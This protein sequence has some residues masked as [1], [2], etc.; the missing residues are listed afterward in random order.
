[1]NGWKVVLIMGLGILAYK[2][3]EALCFMICFIFACFTNKKTGALDTLLDKKIDK[4]KK[5]TKDKKV[6]KKTSS[7]E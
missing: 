6:S 7:K 3:F 5:E 4:D 1:M 2:V